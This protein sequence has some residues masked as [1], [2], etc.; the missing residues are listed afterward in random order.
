[1]N[2]AELA[3]EAGFHERGGPVHGASHAEGAGFHERGSPVH[4]ASTAEGG[5]RP[6]LLALGT[7]DSNIPSFPLLS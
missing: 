3:G 7:S 4:G 5:F 6:G 2:K 1:V